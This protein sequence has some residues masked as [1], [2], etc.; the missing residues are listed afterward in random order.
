MDLLGVIKRS[1]DTKFDISETYSNLIGKSHARFRDE[2]ILAQQNGVSLTILIESAPYVKSLDDVKSW[3]HWGQMRAYCKRNGLPMGTGMFDAI[4]EYVSHGGQ[5]PP[6]S[7]AQ[8][9]KAMCTMAEN[10]GFNWEFCSKDDA[11]VRI[12]DIL[13][14][15]N[16]R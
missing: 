12:I 13:T 5:K 3:I 14:R 9:H 7:G 2:C 11:G 15:D 6:V 4:D 8:L 16:A 1:V 10:Y